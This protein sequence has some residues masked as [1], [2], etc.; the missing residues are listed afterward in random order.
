M[1][2]TPI[3]TYIAKEVFADELSSIDIH[4]LNLGLSGARDINT[5]V[6]GFL[7][8]YIDS[9]EHCSGLVE[10]LYQVFISYDGWCLYMLNTGDSTVMLI[11]KFEN[12]RYTIR[13]NIDPY[14]VVDICEHWKD[15]D[16]RNVEVASSGIYADA[17]KSD[18]CLDSLLDMNNPWIDLMLL[19]NNSL[20]IK[21][22]LLLISRG[23]WIGEL[24]AYDLGIIDKELVRIW[25]EGVSR[26]LK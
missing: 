18:G 1:A 26:V 17:L 16:I 3:Y 12:I 15:Y 14:W 8:D 24:I 4:Y 5:R 2:S 20:P 25:S 13:K 23:S 9:T 6:D 19:R 10:D 21:T 11:H 7:E 22:K